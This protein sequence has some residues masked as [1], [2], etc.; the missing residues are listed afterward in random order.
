MENNQTEQSLD[1]ERSSKIGLTSYNSLKIEPR[2][3]E[4]ISCKKM[5]RNV[6]MNDTPE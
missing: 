4:K 3:S 1:N 6:Y 2:R 5:S